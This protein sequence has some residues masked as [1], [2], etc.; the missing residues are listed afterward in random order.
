[1]N[2][3]V[4]FFIVSLTN[5]MLQTTKT[6]LTV[7]ST[8][9]AAALINAIAFGFYTIVIRLITDVPL[10]WSASLTVVANLFGV[11]LSLCLLDKFK[12][13]KLWKITIT[14]NL[15]DSLPITNELLHY[16]IGYTLANVFYG[17]EILNELNIYSKNQKESQI[18]KE[19]L[20]NFKIKH[21][22]TEA[23]RIL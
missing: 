18:V 23:N 10:V 17:E 7:K 2:M 13:D 16:K 12:K 1:M 9:L 20:E 4:L 8:R 6:I 14:C 21:H 5:V 15:K 22:I 11:Y 3:L 19:I